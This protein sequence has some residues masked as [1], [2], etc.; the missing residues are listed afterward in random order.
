MDDEKTLLIDALLS[1]LTLQWSDNGN[2]M[3]DAVRDNCM[4]L[5]ASLTQRTF[6]EIE[7]LVDAKRQELQ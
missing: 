4:S 6:D 5:I 3:A 7:H 1:A 2:I